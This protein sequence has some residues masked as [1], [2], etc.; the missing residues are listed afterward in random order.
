V[1]GGVDAFSVVVGGIVGVG[2]FFTPSRVAQIVGSSGLALLVWA[3]TGAVV[4]CGA[5]AFAELGGLYNGVGAQYTI[6]R[7]AYGPLPA[8]LFVFCN[9]TAVQGGAIAIVAIVC[10]TNLGI[11][12]GGGPPEGATLFAIAGAIIVGLTAANIVG[13]RVGSGIQNLTV[14]AKVLTLLA[15]G[16]LAA[17]AGPHVVT[18]VPRS[19]GGVAVSLLAA[20]VP[21][22]FTFNGWQQALWIAGEVREPR[23]TLPRAL[24]GGVLT[25]IAVYLL[26]NWAYLRL[27]G[28]Q[29][30]A[31]SQALASD[32]VATVWPSAGRRA[33]AAAVAVSAFG[34][35]NAQLLAGPRL[36]HGMARDGRF[37]SIFGVLG[38][39]TGTP[40][41][42]I[43]LIGGT[44]LFL[45]LTAGTRGV[46][47][48]LLNGVVFV[49]G[50][51]FAL[52][53]AAI[54]VLRR[55]RPDA[56]RPVRVPG[57]PVVPLVF[58]LGEAAAVAGSY[59]DAEVRSAAVIGVL[60]IAAA[61]LLYVA[62]FREPA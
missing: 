41:A 55:K 12:V 37:F 14:L 38:A 42:A 21:A 47:G 29:G 19:G 50:V 28:T 52:S 18:T 26:A 17:V 48:R 27:L 57:Y 6:L 32:A 58:I 54:F 62:R 10:A 5:L 3:L 4:L 46:I 61:A 36:V 16:V 11:A 39:R 1:L 23:R 2:I 7:D 44:S 43:A 35:L 60:W 51:F 8:F 22:F 15:V 31:V 45:L 30:V 53:G 56:D 40:A 9:A 20:L 13:V 49:D 59:L 24:V 34:V 25:V 33:V